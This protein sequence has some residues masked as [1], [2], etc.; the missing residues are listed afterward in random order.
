MDTSKII[1][2]PK[3]DWLSSKNIDVLE[4]DGIYTLNVSEVGDLFI[5]L[6]LI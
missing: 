6:L 4:K 5:G 3:V 1:N 2:L